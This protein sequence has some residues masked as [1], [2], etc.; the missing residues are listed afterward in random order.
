[1]YFI[2]GLRGF[3]ES[4]SPKIGKND[5]PRSGIFRKIPNPLDFL[6]ELVYRA[7]WKIK[8]L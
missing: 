8:N 3:C 2:S 5:D 4:E 6:I 7:F 1:M